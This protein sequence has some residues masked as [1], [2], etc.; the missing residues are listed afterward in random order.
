[1]RAADI[2]AKAS[3]VLRKYPLCDSCLGR[4]FGMRGYSLVN[5]ERGRALKTLLLMEA[6]DAVRSEWDEELLH[7]LAASGFEPARLTLEK[8]K[9]APPARRPCYLCRG[10]MEKVKELAEMCVEAGEEYEYETFQVGCMMPREL[11][12]REEDLWTAYGLEASESLK[13]ELTREVG[14]LV[15]ELTGKRYSPKKPDL[16]FILDLEEWRV[17][18][19]ARP[20][21]IYG[22]YRKLVRGLPQSPW[23]YPP[24]SRVLYAT[25]IEELITEPMIEA[26][27][28][29]D[30]KLHAAGREDLDVRTLGNGRPFIAELKDPKVRNLDLRTLERMINEEAGGLIEVEGLRYVDGKLVPRL[31]AFAEIAK[32]T[33]VARVR[34]GRPIRDDELRMLEREMTN[35][36][37][38]QRTP[39]RVLGRRPDKVRRKV[40]YELKAER[41]SEWEARLIITCQGGLYVKELIHGDEG[42]TQPSVASLLNTSVEV[43]ELDVT[44]IEEPPFIA[45]LASS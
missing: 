22:R 16:L 38:R 45:E 15:Q 6:Y 10:L 28:A 26:T 11:M 25:S 33:Y 44:W 20:L 29:R 2:V 36:V 37:V 39:L 4:L 17:N 24:D 31:K 34:F 5:A 42:R 30:A 43:V 3:D 27:R 21:F 41:L 40:V 23:P 1:M 9:I 19:S 7:V 12:R 18:A 13:S 8:L 14:K 32:K 35:A